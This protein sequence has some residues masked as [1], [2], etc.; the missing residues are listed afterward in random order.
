CFAQAGAPVNFAPDEFSGRRIGKYEVLCRLSIGGMAE[1][2]L[3]FQRGAGGFAKPVV[4]KQLLPDI[5]EDELSVQLF[6]NEA[7]VCAL[8]S[9][10]NIAQVSD[11][12]IVGDELFLVMEF[13]AGAT[14]SDLA[15]KGQLPLGFSLAAVRD[16][17]L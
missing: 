10:P 5:K 13:V 4:L 3:A 2:F 6:M 7:R 12:D 14:V 1:I 11:L 9:H 17:A 15:E 16:V 8:L